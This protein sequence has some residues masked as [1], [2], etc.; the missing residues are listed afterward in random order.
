MTRRIDKPDTRADIAV[1]ACIDGNE[2]KCFVMVAGAGSGKTTSLVKALDYIGKSHG[3]ELRRRQ[4]KVACITYTEVAVSEIWGDVGNNELFH[5]STIHSFL[6]SL[7][8]P[9]QKDIRQWLTVRLEEKLQAARQKRSQLT[10]KAKVSRDKL[11]RDIAKLEAALPKIEKVDRFTYESGKD[12]SKGIL[13]HSD[14]IELVPQLI[15]KHP[16]LASIVA[17]QYPFI[18]VD[19]S[20]DTFRQVV[21]ALVCIATQA[22]GKFCLG[23]FGDPMQQIY[24]HGAGKIE[25]ESGWV[26]IEKPEN[27]RSPSHVL[28]VINKIR[29]DGDGINQIRG[30]HETVDGTLVPMQGSAHLFI[31]PNNNEK[32]KNLARVR[33]WLGQKCADDNWISDTRESDVRILVIVHRMAAARLGFQE[34]FEAF[35]DG[36]PD[37]FKDS[38]LEGTS[39]LLRPFLRVL[40]PLVAATNEN[41]QFDVMNLLRAYCPRLAPCASSLSG[42]TLSSLK[43]DLRKLSE[44]LANSG[45]ASVE[46]VLRFAAD[47]RIIDLDERI[48]EFLHGVVNAKPPA[49]IVEEDDDTDATARVVSAF[50]K[51]PANQLWPYNTYLND[52]SPYSTQHGIKGAEFERVLVVL[53]D[54]EATHFQYSYDKLLGLEPLSKTD[55]ENIAARKESVLDRTRRLFYVCC[56]RATKDL[57]VVLYTNSVDAAR[58]RLKGSNLFPQTQIH[59][60]SELDGAPAGLP[61][62]SAKYARQ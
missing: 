31:L 25:L 50:L 51:C 12:Y 16:L 42:E 15:L 44:L 52:Q 30:R 38:F 37:K 33:A 21:D 28:D 1:K 29:A 14:I 49:T 55:Q 26:R 2:R 7:A 9:F 62:P 57:S 32:T 41:R 53:D 46:E 23:F 36:T 10:A 43:E 48:I 56:S 39:W 34:L 20:Q 8:K 6:W 47:A 22:P 27:F 59:V 61:Q 19:E 60:L 54:E 17:Q 13:G 4:Q 58:S 11:E 18:F 35:N 24:G 3:A 5:V 40:L 45:T